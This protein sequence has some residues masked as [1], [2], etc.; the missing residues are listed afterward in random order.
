M[1][2]GEESIS[3]FKPTHHLSFVKEKEF[4]L[5]DEMKREDGEE[6]GDLDQITLDVKFIENDHLLILILISFDLDLP[7]EE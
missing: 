6:I 7:S 4:P 5:E 3:D 1:V 2:G